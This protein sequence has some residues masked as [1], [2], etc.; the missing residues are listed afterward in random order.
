MA[1]A[2][3][4][5]A[6]GGAGL[7]AGSLISGLGGMG[8]PGMQTLGFG[9]AMRSRRPGQ[10]GSQALNQ[11]TPAASGSSS[12]GNGNNSLLGPQRANNHLQSLGIPPTQRIATTTTSPPVGATPRQW[13][14]NRICCFYYV[15]CRYPDTCA[16]A[17]VGNG[18]K[19]GGKK[20]GRSGREPQGLPQNGSMATTTPPGP[21]GLPVSVESADMTDAQN[22]RAVAD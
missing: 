4:A 5:A 19:Q 21:Q 13:I 3:V 7:A 6:T 2:G 20:P 17:P 22:V 12:T 8:I 10:L 16:K 18:S 14:R 9:L 15:C 11:S 1:V